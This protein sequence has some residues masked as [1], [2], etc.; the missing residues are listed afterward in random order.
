M[1]VSASVV[2][3]NG[4]FIAVA[5]GECGLLAATLPC[6]SAEEAKRRILDIVCEV[7]VWSDDICKQV[8]EKMFR[9]LEGENVDFNYEV[10]LSR[11]TSFQRMVLEEV[12]RIPPGVT[13]TYGE[14]A[15]RVGKPKAA[16]AVG[17]ALK[18][19][20]LPLIIPCH[21]VVG[22]RGVGGYTGGLEIKIKLLEA[23]GA[24]W[25]VKA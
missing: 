4:K 23:E 16:R 1:M 25:A 7:E 12:R 17:S 20:P 19:N 13:L 14:L 18:K 21:R 11:L 9:F 8:A 10:D 6:K 5:R 22:T 2:E 15:R 3:W 24:N